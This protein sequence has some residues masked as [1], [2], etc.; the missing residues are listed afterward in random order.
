MD[1]VRQAFVKNALQQ[2]SVCHAKA[3]FIAEFPLSREICPLF[4]GYRV[5][6]TCQRNAFGY[7]ALSTSEEEYFV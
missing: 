6:D 3:Q 5:L 7:D 1:R 4:D 2:L